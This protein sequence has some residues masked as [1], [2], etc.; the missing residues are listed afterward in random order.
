MTAEVVGGRRVVSR[1]PLWV[2]L[3]PNV[4][5][6]RVIAKAAEEPPGRTL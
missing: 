5:D 1:R 6:I 2:K 3:S 4:T